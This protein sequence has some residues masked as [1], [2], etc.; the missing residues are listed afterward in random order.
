[1]I[2]EQLLNE[3]VYFVAK[4]ISTNKYEVKKA[5]K[6]SNK[7]KTGSLRFKTEVEAQAEADK[8]NK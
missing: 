7:T 5:S 8:L 3:E 1:M 4:N 6:H 2:K